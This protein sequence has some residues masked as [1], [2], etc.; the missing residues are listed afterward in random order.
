MRLDGKKRPSLPPRW[1]IRSFWYS[2]RAL[3]RVSGGSVGLWRPKPNKW[4]ALRLTTIGRR[5]GRKRSVVVGYFE[6][7]RNF[8]TM[9]MN[10]WGEAEPA[11]WLNLR[12]RL[13]VATTLLALL[14]AACG[15][16]G[17]GETTSAAP[18][19]TAA[20]TTCAPTTT[21]T[22]TSTTTR[23]PITTTTAAESTGMAVYFLVDQ[24]DDDPPGPFLVPVYR[25]VTA[26]EN[27]AQRAV[28]LLVAGPTE[29][30]VAGVPAISTAIPEGTRALGASVEDRVATVNLSGEFDDGGGSLAM[31]AR[32]AEVVYTL[33]GLPDIDA[34][35]VEIDGEPVN[36]FS[37]EG[38]E[39]NGPQR[40]DDYFDLLP[41]I[42]VDR[43]AWGEPV[44]NP[45]QVSGLSNVF[46]A[47]S[48]VML[49]DDD[50]ETLFEDTVMASC[51]TGCWGEWSIEIP[52]EVDRDQ[53]GALI[54]WEFSAKD[55]SRIHIREY[56]VQLR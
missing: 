52:F 7:G 1:F 48:Q 26:S 34:V 41:P 42:F 55:G 47:V 16:G 30:E 40:R 36:V 23:G 51:G 14:L 39:L 19:P 22:H 4:G 2:H 12:G 24:L 35:A 50:G 44:T 3:L 28:E 20:P 6:D 9:A 56:P 37:S 27:M 5:T 49:T 13:V 32:L 25:A 17:R 15:P 45:I 31:F 46:E 54:V 10:G 53:V 11:W 21:S 33:T 38:I 29:D 43:P 18:I 8:V